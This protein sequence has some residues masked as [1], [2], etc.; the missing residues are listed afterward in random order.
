[1]RSKHLQKAPQAVCVILYRN[2]LV[3]SISRGTNTSDWNIPGGK[4][5]LGESLREAA[6]RELYEETGVLVPY[7]KQLVPVY[8]S[9]VRTHFCTCFLVNGDVIFPP[10]M[11]SSPFE[12]YVA[13]AR[14]DD[15]ITSRSRFFEYNRNAFREAGII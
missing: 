10:A 13:W 1:M 14:P 11:G 7:R 9:M 3:L 6:A 4:V 8:A 2:G 15:L 12:G 5:D